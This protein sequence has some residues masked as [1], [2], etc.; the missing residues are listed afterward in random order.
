MNLSAAGNDV[1]MVSCGIVPL[2]DRECEISDDMD[3]HA[4]QMGVTV[5]LE[6]EDEHLDLCPWAI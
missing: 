4:V 5:S 6:S 3:H 2:C 1:E